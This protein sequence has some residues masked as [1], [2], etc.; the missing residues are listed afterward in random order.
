M[1]A[2]KHPLL[3]M[4]NPAN[5]NGNRL[6]GAEESRLLKTFTAKAPSQIPGRTRDPISITAASATPDG[7]QSG[8]ACPP[9]TE[10]SSPNWPVRK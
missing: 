8:E 1:T 10:N 2:A 9:G 6:I 7:N 5:V 4:P 3:A